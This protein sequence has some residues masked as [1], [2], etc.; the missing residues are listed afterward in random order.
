[1]NQLN[2]RWLGLAPLFD[3][4][5]GITILEPLN[6][7]LGWWV[8]APS[9]LYDERT[10]RFYLYYRRRKPRELGRGTNCYIAESVDGIE[11]ATIW[12]ASKADLNTPSMEKAALALTLEGKAHLYIS[13]ID[14]EDNKW[15]T[16]LIAGEH[17]D[18]LDIR[19]RV[20]IFTA[21]DINAEGVKDP[22]VLIL[23]GLYYMILSYAPSPLRA[24]LTAT[25]GFTKSCK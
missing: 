13:Y 24:C 12:E 20:K 7:G 10:E 16:D 2:K 8:G 18:R 9:A 22:Y 23:G 3:P 11:F 4:A 15:R 5:E 1:M 17:F 6:A 25:V 14:P 19:N 21:D